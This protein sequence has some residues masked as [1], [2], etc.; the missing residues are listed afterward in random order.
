MVAGGHCLDDKSREEAREASAHASVHSGT[1]HNRSLGDT[2][3]DTAEDGLQE[4]R[5][6]VV[7]VVDAPFRY[8]GGVKGGREQEV[9]HCARTVVE[10]VG[11]PQEAA[12]RLADPTNLPSQLVGVAHMAVLQAIGEAIAVSR[13]GWRSIARAL[14]PHPCH[15]ASSN[16]IFDKDVNQT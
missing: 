10:A 4:R 12:S 5:V 8:D 16:D 14:L 2:A 9:R 13:H 15:F 1:A 3:R 7:V 6:V 11:L